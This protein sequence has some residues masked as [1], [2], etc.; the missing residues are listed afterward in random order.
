MG[1]AHGSRER[2]GRSLPIFARASARS[3]S[4]PAIALVGQM[5]HLGG[6]FAGGML[7]WAGGALVAA[8]LTGSRGALAVAL[9]AGSV[10][11]GMRVFET[12]DVPH[13]AV[14]GAL[15]HCRRSCARLEFA[16]GGSSRR[17]GGAS[18]VDRG[19]GSSSTSLMSN[20]PSFSQVARRCCSAAGLRWPRRRGR[21]RS[22]GAVLSTYGAFS[23]A[24]VAILE[25]A[26]ANELLRSKAGRG[27]PLWAISCG[28][29]G[30]DAGLC[31]R[32]DDAPGRHRLCR[33]RDRAGPCRG[34]GPAA[35]AIGR[36][37]ACSTPL[38]SAPCSASSCPAC[39][40][41]SARASSPAG[42][43]WPASSR[44]SPG[45]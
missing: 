11:S 30:A 14:R 39:L 36:A 4:A 31:R 22:A 6:D 28:V 25:V 17:A 19:G 16:R 29:A 7:L 45:R 24:G 44:P 34:S 21:G 41:P 38:R 9:V 8:A 42:S 20:G 2:A 40:M 37:M 26:M 35:A 23:L 5:Y 1:L 3:S 27:Q 43:D 18:V 33:K 12:H 10:W 32:R 15:A 13:L